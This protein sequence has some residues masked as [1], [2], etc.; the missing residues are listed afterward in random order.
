M[1]DRYDPF[2]FGLSALSQLVS[3]VHLQLIASSLELYFWQ[4]QRILPETRA[5]N[6]KWPE[7]NW[8]N[9]C[10][11]VRPSSGCVGISKNSWFDQSVHQQW[12]LWLRVEPSVP[13]WLAC[14]RD[15]LVQA[16]KVTESGLKNPVIDKDLQSHW[17]CAAWYSRS[18][19]LCACKSFEQLVW[20]P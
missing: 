20:L 16:L 8:I 9:I 17:P 19:A 14:I 2:G 13:W 10:K 1:F 11:H 18:T 7:F 15:Y 5:T 6:W 3:L 4:E 12:D